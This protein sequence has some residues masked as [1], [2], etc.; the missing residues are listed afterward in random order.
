MRLLNHKN[1]IRLKDFADLQA[2]YVLVMELML[3]GDLFERL[4]KQVRP[5][6]RAA[7]TGARR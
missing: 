1:I 4:E 6:A 2:H 3:G 5:R 7:S